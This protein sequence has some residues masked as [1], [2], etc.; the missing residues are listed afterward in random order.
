[1]RECEPGGMCSEYSVIL[2]QLRSA[3]T[4]P[5]VMRLLVLGVLLSNHRG[6]IF[7]RTSC[8]GTSLLLVQDCNKNVLF[9]FRGLQFKKHTDG[10]GRTG[11]AAAAARD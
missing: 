6:G 10:D 11:P 4:F 9:R 3:H 8:L 2:F 7:V 5:P 1:M